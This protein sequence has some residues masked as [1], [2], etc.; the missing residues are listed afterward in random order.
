M[1]EQPERKVIRA[2]P[3]LRML[4]LAGVVVVVV[5]GVVALAFTE[6]FL[7]DMTELARESPEVAAARVGFAFKLVALSAAVIPVAV[8]V[9]LARVAILAWRSG[10]FPPRGT[11]VLRDTVVTT[12]PRSLRWA[13]LALL[14]AL[15][16]L[17]GG[18]GIPLVAWNLVEGL[19]LGAAA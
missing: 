15:L 19:S 13:L 14:V 8:G 7:R 18:I 10:E 16:L 11:R 6:S 3:T 17:L 4:T 12:G 2:D 1:N 5:A 9:Y